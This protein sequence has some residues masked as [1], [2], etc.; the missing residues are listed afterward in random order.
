M[1]SAFNHGASPISEL[2]R[3]RFILSGA[4]P[5]SRPARED[6]R[7]NPLGRPDVTGIYMVRSP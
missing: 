7:S 5:K 1:P 6:R 4:D 3:G 2:I